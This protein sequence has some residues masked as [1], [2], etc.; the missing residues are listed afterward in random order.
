MRL[1]V[2]T[3]QEKCEHF[4]ICVYQVEELD[5]PGDE[6]ISDKKY[7][8]NSCVRKSLSRQVKPQIIN[9][10]KCGFKFKPLNPR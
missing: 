1:G 4:I 2:L 9:V 10:D 7:N 6:C 5:L 3:K 8:F